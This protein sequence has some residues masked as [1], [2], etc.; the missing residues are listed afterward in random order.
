MR[1]PEA[2]PGIQ[3]SHAASMGREPKPTR[4]AVI[5]GICCLSLLLIGMDVTIVNVAIPALQNSFGASVQDMQWVIDGYTLVIASLL[6]L[7]GSISDR[8]GRKRTFLAGLFVFTSASLLCSLASNV[9]LLIAFRVLQGLGASM[10]NPVALSIVA[11]AFPEP[12]ARAQAIGIWGAVFGVALGLGPI[13]GGLLT[14]TI[15]WRAIFLVNVPVGIAA[16]AL[17]AWY[18]PESKAARGRAFD[19]GGQLLM[20]T[21]LGSLTYAVIDGQQ[22]GWN[23]A[24][25]I[26]MFVL[27]AASIAGLVSYERQLAE[28]LLDVR[29]FRSTPFSG[30]TLIAVMVFGCF[31]AILFLNSL[32]VQQERGFSA[33]EAG[34]CTLPLA[35]MA[36]L[37][38]PLSGR[39]VA[40]HGTRPSL[41]IAGTAM[42]VSTLLLADLGHAGSIVQLLL[43]YAIF[44]VGL[45]TVNPAIATVAVAGMP[46]SQTGVAA[47]IASTSRQIGAALGVALA[48]AAVH[49]G[50]SHGMGVAQATQPLWWVMSGLGACIIFLAWA[51]NTRWAQEGSRRVA[52]LLVQETD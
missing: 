33:L 5:L 31:A 24:A 32:Y 51:T 26:G 15:G 23:S 12:K 13:V 1:S 14:Q 30:A 37:C 45:G 8:Y 16:L 3:A 27:S 22:L 21:A 17:T 9:H 43:A 2:R 52:A 47:A 38:G 6:M 36:A 39:L 20:M 11:Q 4:P 41:F 49:A 10:L 34:L 46:R 19:P 28:P 50:R 18:V 44:G 25:V 35:L 42:M 48:G 29:F 40:H 7:T